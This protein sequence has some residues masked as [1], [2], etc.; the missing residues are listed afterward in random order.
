MAILHAEEEMRVEDVENIYDD[1][2]LR[3]REAAER[4]R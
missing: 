4:A 3:E 2:N 1:E